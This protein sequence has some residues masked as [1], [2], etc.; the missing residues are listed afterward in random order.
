M[1]RSYLKIEDRICGVGQLW[2][3]VSVVA[4][5]CVVVIERTNLKENTGPKAMI[6]LIEIVD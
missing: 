3:V 1:N 6:I 2:Q 5:L 4:H